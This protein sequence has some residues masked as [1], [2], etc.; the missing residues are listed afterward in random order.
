MSCDLRAIVLITILSAVALSGCISG[1]GETIDTGDED[2]QAVVTETHGS[3]KGHIV[4]VALDDVQG[5]S[6]GLVDAAGDMVATTQ[7]D[8]TGRFVINEVEPGTYRLQVSAACCRLAAT[9]VDVKAN[10][11]AEVNLQL[12][13]LTSDDL[14][15]PSHVE[16]E[17]HG[18]ISCGVSTPAVRAAVCSIPGALDD[19]LGDPNE[20]FLLEFQVKRGL[21]SL[22][23][24]MVWDSVGGV[25]APEF[26]LSVDDPQCH[27]DDCSYQY[28]SKDEGSP[29]V[30]RV[31]NSDI[32]PDE[33]KWDAITDER[34]IRMRVF[35]GGMASLVYQ[36]PFSIY[37]HEFYWAEAPQDFNP[38]PDF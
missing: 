4:T 25:S 8:K 23:V 12:E 32:G 26:S 27:I 30:I 22:V 7:T 13:V 37:Y 15:L 36:Q 9:S 34:T 6:V 33:W 5:G 19:S 21:K 1:D 29:I 28:A 11:V 20:D 35:A 16:N 38:I 24:G 14:Q 31:D 10:Q 3:I 2:P 17:W 18:F